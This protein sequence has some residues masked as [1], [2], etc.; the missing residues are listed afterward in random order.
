MKNIDD[1][2]IGDGVEFGKKGKRL[3]NIFTFEVKKTFENFE[4]AKSS[5]V[6]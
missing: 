2:K 3:E 6:C 1:N 5:L 4:R